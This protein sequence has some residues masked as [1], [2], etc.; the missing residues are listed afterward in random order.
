MGRVRVARARGQ[1]PR[2]R[3]GADELVKGALPL[4]IAGIRSRPVALQ[5]TQ[6]LQDLEALLDQALGLTQ[7]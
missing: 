4:A 5:S 6:P 1:T 7:R 2:V 3:E